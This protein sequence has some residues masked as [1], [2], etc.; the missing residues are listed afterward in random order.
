MTISTQF[1]PRIRM[2]PLE[3]ND[4][5]RGAIPTCPVGE[6]TWLLYS[7]VKNRPPLIDNFDRVYLSR[8]WLLR[9]GAS[10]HT[11]KSSSRKQLP[12]AG[13]Y[14]AQYPHEEL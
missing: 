7:T 3:T 2:S 1:V 13:R 10:E 5:K 11:M 12:A 4:T 8:T 9:R 14:C 6:L